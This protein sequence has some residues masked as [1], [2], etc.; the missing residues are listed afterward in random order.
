MKDICMFVPPNKFKNDLEFFHFVYETN[1]KKLL[2][3]FCHSICHLQIVYKGTAVLRTEEGTFSLKKN[4]IFFTFPNEKYYLDADNQFAFLYIS[5]SGERGAS[6][7]SEKNITEQNCVFSMPEELLLFW[8]NAITKTN[9][10]NAYLL[11]ES[12]FSYTLSLLSNTVLGIENESHEKIDKILAYIQHNFTSRD[13]SIKKIADLF[14]YSEKYISHLF[15]LK[16]G[17]KFSQYINNLR[18]QYAIELIKKG[19]GSLSE[20]ATKCGFS[21]PFY[22]SKVFKKET[23]KSPSEYQ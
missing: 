9:S 7:L 3:P 5:F 6:L 21:D 19:E 11:A 22:F 18:I 4:D 15:V 16:T 17:V 1:V 12:V 13:I 10:D 14:F 2:Q 8:I 23:G 20:I